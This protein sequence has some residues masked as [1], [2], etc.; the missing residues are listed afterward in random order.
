MLVVVIL[1]NLKTK[2]DKYMLTKGPGCV[3]V[4]LISRGYQ[5]PECQV[6]ETQ[7]IRLWRAWAPP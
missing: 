6:C 7:E 1:E 4:V 3:K 5:C 2:T